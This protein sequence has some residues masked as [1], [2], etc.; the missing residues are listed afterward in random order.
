MQC[1][2]H[3]IPLSSVFSNLKKV[4]FNANLFPGKAA[5]LWV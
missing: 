4:M 3:D 1:M 5:G 2:A